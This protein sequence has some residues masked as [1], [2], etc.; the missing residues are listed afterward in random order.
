MRDQIGD[1]EYEE[2]QRKAKKLLGRLDKFESTLK[3]KAAT[4]DERR[5]ALW[6]DSDT[7]TLYASPL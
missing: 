2:T 6:L 5:N 7:C 1:E 4:V 3:N